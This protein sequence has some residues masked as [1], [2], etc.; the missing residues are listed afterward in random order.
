MAHSVYLY[1]KVFLL[2][3]YNYKNINDM[4]NKEINGTLAVNGNPINFE[5]SIND[6]TVETIKNKN[7]HLT[8]EQAERVLAI[9]REVVKMNERHEECPTKT[10]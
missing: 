1:L 4:K 6:T 3:V 5:V 8:D 7:K 2:L 10:N 9:I